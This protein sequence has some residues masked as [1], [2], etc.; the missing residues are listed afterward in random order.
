MPRTYYASAISTDPPS[1]TVGAME[2]AVEGGAEYTGS[3]GVALS[4][5]EAL[6]QRTASLTPE[7]EGG[8]AVTTDVIG[9]YYTLA[10]H[11]LTPGEHYYVPMVLYPVV[12][13]HWEMVV[14]VV[15]P[16]GS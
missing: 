5:V 10:L 15:C 11:N 3:A 13:R 8:A 12:G 4:S 16:G 6:I 1:I 7:G 2:S 9:S 14:V